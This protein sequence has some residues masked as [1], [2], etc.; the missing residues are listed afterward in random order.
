V[1]RAGGKDDH[2]AGFGCEREAVFT[3]ELNRDFAFVNAKDFVTVT[4][5]VVE[6]KHAVS[7]SGRPA[8]AR[9]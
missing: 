1:R 5:I 6:R 7:P 8:V 2:V 4:V 3:A 9:E